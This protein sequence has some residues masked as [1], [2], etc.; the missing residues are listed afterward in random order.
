MA[1]NLIGT[2]G[3]DGVVTTTWPVEARRR[4]EEALLLSER[5][6]TRAEEIAGL[7]HW[8]GSTSIPGSSG[9]RTG[10]RHSTACTARSDRWPMSQAIPLPEYRLP[11][12]RALQELVEQG[13]T[14]RSGVRDP[15][16]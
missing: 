11:L 5:R 9:L 4:A 13:P 15:P 16:R 14:V 12:D 2:P 3:V 7:G 1:A 8:E 6:F 10:R